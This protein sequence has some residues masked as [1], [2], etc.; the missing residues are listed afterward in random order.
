MLNYPGHVKAAQIGVQKTIP[1]VEVNGLR[2]DILNQEWY[3][4]LR[5]KGSTAFKWHIPGNRP[6]TQGGR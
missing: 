4:I 5:T 2:R 6:V 1:D 3:N